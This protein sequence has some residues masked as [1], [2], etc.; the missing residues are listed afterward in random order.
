MGDVPF[1]GLEVWRSTSYGRVEAIG[2]GKGHLSVDAEKDQHLKNGLIS[3]CDFLSK[4][5]VR[6]NVSCTRIPQRS[7]GEESVCEHL[8]SRS[9][10]HNESCDA[11][12][13]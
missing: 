13:V 11:Q 9:E 7:L 1:R 2:V 6:G 10:A 5:V 4:K 3:T 8:V 12:A